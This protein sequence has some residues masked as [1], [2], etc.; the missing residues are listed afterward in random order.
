MFFA[1]RLLGKE[2][3]GAATEQERK[4]LRLLTPL[5]K[6]FT[7][8]QAVAVVSEILECFG[9][10]GYVE[11]TGLP[12]LLRD[13]QVLTIWEG[14]TNVLS[15]DL[16]RVLR[17]DDALEALLGDLDRATRT[18]S[19]R[20]SHLRGRAFAR[21]SIRSGDTSPGSLQPTAR[22]SKRARGTLR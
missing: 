9:G 8:K 12:V 10:A 20:C 22:R 7:A 21:R 11:D 2:E 1:A 18:R 13:S 14:T 5:A 16:L 3:T 15:L 17:R 6:L 4:L 19:P